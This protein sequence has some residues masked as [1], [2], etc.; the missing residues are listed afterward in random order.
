M[1]TEKRPFYCLGW[2][3]TGWIGTAALLAWGG[4][5]APA[6]PQAA[7]SG[8][9]ITVLEPDEGPVGTEVVIRGENFGPSIGSV[10]GTSGV[11]FGGVW[12]SPSA[13]SEGEVRVEVPAGATTGPVVVTVGGVASE[14]LAFTVT[15]TGTGSPAVG[16]VSPAQGAAGT[17]V[18]I[19]GENFGPPEG[20]EQGT[21]GVSFNG[22]AGTP[23]SWS[24]AEI[25]VAV[26]EGAP[27][28][29]VVVTVEGRASDGVGFAVAGPAPVIET[30]DPTHGPEGT[31]V[32]IRGEHFGSPIAA[33]QGRSGV[34]FN[35]V[36]GV[37]THWSEAEIRAAVPEGVASGLVAVAVGGRATESS[38]R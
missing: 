35:G 18:V 32:V 9:A 12:A 10:Q 13:W 30:V 5:A 24:E 15:G 19:R 17:E 20:A 22:V 1:K 21:A 36:W 16:T 23:A 38:S 8:P 2:S 28:G 11:S 29:L 33:A 3:L 26:P 34:R 4:L 7:L 6:A 14:G 25:R 37:P 31:G 27:S